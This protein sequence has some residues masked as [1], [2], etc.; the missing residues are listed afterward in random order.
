[1]KAFFSILLLILFFTSC[2]DFLE[3]DLTEDSIELITPMNN[4]VTLESNMTFTWEA[5]EGATGYEIQIVAPSFDSILSFVAKTDLGNTIR[6]DTSLLAGSYEWKLIGY[7]SAY[8]TESDIFQ[9]EILEDTLGSLLGKSISLLSPANNEITNDTTISFLWENLPDALTYSIQV[10]DPDFS[11]STFIFVDEEIAG[12]NY[13]TPLDEGTYR[14][15]VRGENDISVSPYIERVFTIDR[16][17]PNAPTLIA[18][19]QGDTITLPVTLSWD[20][21]AT[22]AMDTVYVYSD[23]LMS[24][25]I[26]QVATTDADLE[27]DDNTFNKYY[28]RVRSADSAGNTSDFSSLEKFYVQ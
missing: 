10:A 3:D 2:S 19:I 27:F 12:D 28:W 18:P 5:L 23:S 17:P 21:D 26:L 4:I 15:R 20:F 25:P 13:S 24:A 9:F 22:A 7:N 8:E 6:F 16:T 11:N 14:W 1:M